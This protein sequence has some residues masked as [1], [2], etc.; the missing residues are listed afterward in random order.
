[1]TRTFALIALVAAI[2]SASFADAQAPY[3]LDAKGGCHAANGRFAAKAM[4]AAPARKPVC[5]DLKG[6]FAKCGTPGARP[7]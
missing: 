5:R 7:I 1:M 4:C 3:K 2:G 6:R